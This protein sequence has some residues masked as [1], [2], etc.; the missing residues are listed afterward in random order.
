MFPKIT[1][2]QVDEGLERTG[3]HPALYMRYLKRFTEDPTFYKLS[4]ALDQGDMHGA[5][6][7][8]HT[9]KGVTAQLGITALS[10]HAETLCAL[11]RSNTPE[12]L[13]EARDL[14]RI[15]LTPVYSE[16]IRQIKALP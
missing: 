11:L 6:L 10:K 16:I 3:N 13:N 14:F 2:I 5:F 7:H 15:I 4:D 1:G 12:N 9:L 8:A